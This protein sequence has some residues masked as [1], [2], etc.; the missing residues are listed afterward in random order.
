MWSA[1]RRM[2]SRRRG[3]ADRQS[4][5]AAVELALLLPILL[6]LVFGIVDFGFCFNAQVSLSQAARE[7]ARAWS[8]GDTAGAA[9]RV[10]AAAGLSPVDVTAGHVGPDGKIQAGVACPASPTAAD[11]A[12]VKATYEVDLVSPFG[13]LAGFDSITVTGIGVMRCLG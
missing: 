9:D 12:K 10:R 4:G 6:V 2:S 13:A 3:T 5:A 7:G 1:L 11:V 8:L